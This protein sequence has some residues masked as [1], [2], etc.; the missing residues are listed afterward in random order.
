MTGS[1]TTTT[2]GGDEELACSG[3]SPFAA[4]PIPVPA[5][6][7]ALDGA[8]VARG[9][10]VDPAAGLSEPEVAAR[11]L[12]TGP[13]ELERE[14]PPSLLRLVG[15]Q[16]RDAMIL[17][18]LA[19]ALLT[20]VTGDLAD[21]AVI[22][23][24]VV[25]NTVVGVLQERRAAGAIEALRSMAVPSAVV[26][27]AGHRRTVPAASVVPGDV[28]V[29]AEGALVVADARLLEASGLEVDESVLTGESLPS[30]R[31]PAPAPS[32]AGVADRRSMVH[33][34]TLV[35]HGSGIAVVVATGAQGALGSIAR[36]VGTVAAGPT[37]LQR[38]MSGLGRGLALLAIAG[39]VL[40]GV[41][42]LLQGRPWEITLVTAVSLAVAAVPESLPA[43]VS[44]A[45]ATGARRMARRG[46]VVRTLGAVETLGSV[47]VL[48]SDKT[49]TLTTGRMA[50]VECWTPGGEDRPGLLR[51]LALCND[52]SADGATGGMTDLAL[53]KAAVEGG[54]S[55]SA[56]RER[57]PLVGEIPFDHERKSMSTTHAGPEGTFTLT[58]GAPEKVLTTGD[59]AAR[60]V[61]D[62]WAGAGRRVIAVHIAD[63]AG[64]RVMGLVAIADPVRLEA[65]AAIRGLRAAG[66]ATVLITGDHAGTA[67]AVARATGVI[68]VDEVIA[69]DDP[70]GPRVHARADP[71][72]KLR[73]I[74]D[75]RRAGQVV[76]MT[77][78]G[79]NDAPALRAADIGVAM[80]R[81]GTDVARAAADLV[82]TDDSLH[83]VVAAVGEGRRVYDNIRRFVRYG[84]AGGLAEIAVMLIGPWLGMSLPLL[85]G[86]ILWVNLLT[87][88]LPG[89]A[90]GAEQAE[91]DVLRRGPRPPGEA[92]ITGQ[93]A[94]QIVGIGAAVTVAVLA[95][96]LW[97]RAHDGAWQTVLFAT[98]AATQ[99]GV[100]LATRSDTRPL[101]NPVRGNRMLMLAVAA[102]GAL[103]LAAVYLPPL[104]AVLRTDPLGLA[105]LAAV[106]VAAPF[107]GLAALILLTV[108]AGRSGR[109]V[110]GPTAA[111]TRR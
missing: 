87:H 2:A 92:L 61:A 101:R 110:P 58:K 9:L 15:D 28:L 30:R 14:R 22:T 23:L 81:R 26:R 17:V 83:T 85:A 43:V 67:A 52:A 106:A 53:L 73:L 27:R 57:C 69:A 47:T 103:L 80:G 94:R 60:A 32:T 4:A 96:A 13:N 72:T 89:V 16:L 99:L 109:E 84:L 24:V 65:P 19:A 10:T 11:L 33:A 6:P 71:E 107:P 38:R 75:W 62:G 111:A 70:V 90:I 95:A 46:A 66:V 31:D 41:L 35:T 1:T 55:P 108:T 64:P 3:P 56:E 49:G 88:G 7:W 8:A 51:A 63:D 105:D 34:G 18:L 78:D 59:V 74:D 29:L 79:V 97:S 44:L 54:V 36:L 48:A 12:A 93:L 77:G 91:P 82:L 50:V 104:A 40:V 45:L 37:P 76:A 102:S 21:T 68:G 39:S 5:R 86:Q 100:A 98:L 42:G 25:V 20:V